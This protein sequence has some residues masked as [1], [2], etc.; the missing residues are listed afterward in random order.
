MK[1]IRALI[2]VGLISVGVIS[3][4]DEAVAQVAWVQVGVGLFIAGVVYFRGG[5]ATAKEGQR[6]SVYYNEDTGEYCVSAAP[7]F[8][9]ICD[10]YGDQCIP[11]LDKPTFRSSVFE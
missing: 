2:A 5:P 9:T 6:W 10:R 7:G 4:W 3:S 8:C 1:R 11:N